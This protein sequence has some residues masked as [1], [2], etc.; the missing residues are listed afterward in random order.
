[1]EKYIE[2]LTLIT[3]VIY[4]ILEIRQKNL[5]WVLG[6]LT[7]LASMWMFYSRGAYASFILNL[8]YLV[9]AFIGLWQWGADRKRL[10]DTD[11]SRKEDTIYLRKLT[12]VTA[13]AGAAAMIILTFIL[14]WGM[15]RMH[16]AGFLRENPMS[17]LDAS[18]ASVSVIASWWLVKSYLQQWWLWIA[19]NI[20]SV[21]LC[22][23]Y[24]MWWMSLMYGAYAVAAAIGLKHWK[25]HGITI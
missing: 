9:T 3:G 4:V 2:L 11:S 21:I 5:M 12:P 8:Y 16:A 1:M 10:T 13:A 23:S 25:K 17:I 14:S 7:S 24:G 22:A 20:L 6:I 19:A 18:I 15:D